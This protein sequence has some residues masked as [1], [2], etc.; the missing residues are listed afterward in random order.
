MEPHRMSLCLQPCFSPVGED[1]MPTAEWDRANIEAMKKLYP[2]YTF[3]CVDMRSFD[4]S[5]RLL[6]LHARQHGGIQRRCV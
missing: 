2:G 1:G 3:Y 4:G 5:R 6:Q